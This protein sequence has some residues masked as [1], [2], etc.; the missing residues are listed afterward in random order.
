[1]N[2]KGGA[3]PELLNQL[4]DVPLSEPTK[5]KQPRSGLFLPWAVVPGKKPTANHKTA[6]RSPRSH[7]MKEMTRFPRW[8]VADQAERARQS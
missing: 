7:S 1:M 4:I 5:R 6:D 3:H 2:I 8:L